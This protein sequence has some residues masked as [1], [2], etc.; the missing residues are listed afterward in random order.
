MAFMDCLE[1]RNELSLFSTISGIIPDLSKTEVF[2]GS[3]QSFSI[4]IILLCQSAFQ[5]F[6]KHELQKP[7]ALR[8]KVP[9]S[10]GLF[11]DYLKH[12]LLSAF[13]V[14]CLQSLFGAEFKILIKLVNIRTN[15]SNG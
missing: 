12:L 11:L 7:R 2:A 8:R 4:F 6:D 15:L 5:K 3:I 9:G 10:S 1:C 13:W 14:V